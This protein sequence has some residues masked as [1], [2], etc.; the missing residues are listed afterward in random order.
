MDD[1][2]QQT[3]GGGLG[4]KGNKANAASPISGK[5]RIYIL[6]KKLRKKIVIGTDIRSHSALNVVRNTPYSTRTVHVLTCIQ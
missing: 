2:K 1:C 3:A 4:R 6:H 5:W